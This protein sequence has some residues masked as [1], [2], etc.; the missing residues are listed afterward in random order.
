MFMVYTKGGTTRE[1]ASVNWSYKEGI[2]AKN[3]LVFKLP[4]SLNK[5]ILAKFYSR[6]SA[7]EWPI[8]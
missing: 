6:V 8:Q 1:R 2:I 3:V 7:L 4:N 5:Q